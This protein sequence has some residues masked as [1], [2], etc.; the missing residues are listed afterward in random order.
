MR[1]NIAEI[2]EMPTV[3]NGVHESVFRSYHTLAF[4]ERLLDDG[5]GVDVVRN[6]ISE[7]RHLDKLKRPTCAAPDALPTG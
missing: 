1:Y 6:I 4:V 2:I 7:F 5:A 3:V